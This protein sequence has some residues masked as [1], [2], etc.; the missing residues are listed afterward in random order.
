MEG[1]VKVGFVWEEK[2]GGKFAKGFGKGR[3]CGLFVVLVAC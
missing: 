3:F 1:D 2:G